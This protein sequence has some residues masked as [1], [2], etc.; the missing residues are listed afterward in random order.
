MTEKTRP[1]RDLRDAPGAMSD[2]H[3]LSRLL[4]WLFFLLLAQGLS[5]L[6]LSLALLLPLL[7]GTSVRQRGLRLIW[8]TRWLLLSLFL[9]F[10]WG[11]AGE[12]LWASAYAPS[13]EGVQVALMQLGRLVLVLLLVAALLES[14]PLSDF[15]L[16]AHGLLKPLRGIGFDADRGVVRLMLVLRYVETLPRPR[17]WRV[18]LETQDD[19]PTT[20]VEL[21]TRPL[22]RVDWLLMGLLLLLCANCLNFWEWVV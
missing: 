10:A 8:R 4:F 2:L 7:L 17:D 13:V 6:P 19:L 16:A 22:R 14:M 18:L 12:P 20:S 21:Q 5:A 1:A 15:L 3:P 9:F 11:G